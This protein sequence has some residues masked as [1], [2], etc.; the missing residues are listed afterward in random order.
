M[1]AVTAPVQPTA[2]GEKLVVSDL[3]NT[4]WWPCR[5]LHLLYA[6]GA[7]AR[8]A[9]VQVGYN[10]VPRRQKPERANPPTGPAS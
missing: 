10:A 3:E 8:F 2:V 1:S 5:E 9:C 6:K 7:W 4:L